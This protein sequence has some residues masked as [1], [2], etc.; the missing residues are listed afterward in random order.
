MQNSARWPATGNP[1][2]AILALME[3][4]ENTAMRREALFSRHGFYSFVVQ[5]NA[6]LHREAVETGVQVLRALLR[7]RDPGATF[8]VLD[9]ACGGEPIAVSE[10]LAACPDHRFHY[11]GIDINPDQVDAARAFAYP[12]NVVRARIDEASAWDLQGLNV[13]RPYDLVFMGMNL[14]HGT[15]EEILFL[16]RELRAVLAPHGVFMNHDWFR[17][18]EQPYHRRPDCNP[19]RPSESYRLVEPAR[20]AQAPGPV[21]DDKAEYDGTEDSS[22]RVDFR[23]LLDQRLLECGAEESGANATRDHVASRDYPI[24]LREFAQLFG[25]Q[26]FQVHTLRYPGDEPLK[27]YIAMPVASPDAAVIRR[28]QRPAV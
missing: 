19:D 16:A 13:E 5:S 9:L 6:L 25:Q 20:L 2:L 7:G 23:T 12:A 18:D 4:H 15:P 26:N 8:A 3:D 10:I 21:L 28:L 11:H 24:S 1:A 27:R 22:W 14:H 17:P